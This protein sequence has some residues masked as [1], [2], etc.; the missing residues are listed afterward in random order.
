MKRELVVAQGA[1]GEVLPVVIGYLAVVVGGRRE[2]AVS[3]D[4]GMKG[5]YH[6]PWDLASRLGS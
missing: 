3:R 6:Q 2:C 5:T 4:W 1:K